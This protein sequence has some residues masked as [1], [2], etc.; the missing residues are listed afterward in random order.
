MNDDNHSTM[1]FGGIIVVIVI[2][3]VCLKAIKALFLEMG[4]TFDAFGIMASSFLGALWGAAQMAFLGA[5]IL[6]SVAAGIYFTYRY[7]QMV[8]Q[9]T[10]IQRAVGNSID[11]FQYKMAEELQ[12]FRTDMNRRI[13]TVEF[14]LHQ[15]LEES[16]AVTMPALESVSTGE[17]NLEAAAE[18]RAEIS[19]T[20]NQGDSNTTINTVTNPY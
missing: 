7:I 1:F 2:G 20:E 14:E 12:E 11:H 10:D 6:G 15:A 18:P 16:T 13:K 19:M 3:M 4:R 17:S 5:L 9:A 8:R